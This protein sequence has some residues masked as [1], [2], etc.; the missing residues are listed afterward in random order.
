MTADSLI[1]DAV[2]SPTLA[3]DGTAK[4]RLCISGFGGHLCNLDAA[5]DWTLYELKKAVE[6]ATGITIWE[7]E[8]HTHHGAVGRAAECMVGA[9]HQK[10]LGRLDEP[11]L[12]GHVQRCL[13]LVV[14]HRKADPELQ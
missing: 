12:C 11:T 3:S 14:L 9:L 8:S 10:Q 7:Q 6:E 1:A 5:P 2:Y 13:T 4:W